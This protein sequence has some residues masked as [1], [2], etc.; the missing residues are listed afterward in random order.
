MFP[1][2]HSK[3]TI[4]K[5]CVSKTKQLQ[6][7]AA[8]DRILILNQVRH[9]L[10]VSTMLTAYHFIHLQIMETEKFYIWGGWGLGM[11]RALHM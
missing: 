9:S 8:Q 6:L 7:A 4:L 2:S 3:I 11:G 1:M 10:S 5:T